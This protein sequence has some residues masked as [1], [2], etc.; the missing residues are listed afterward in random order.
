MPNRFLGICFD[1]TIF[2][3]LLNRF[4]KL[5]SSLCFQQ[6]YFNRFANRLFSKQWLRFLMSIDLPIDLIACSWKVFTW[7]LVQSISQSI[8]TKLYQNWKISTIDCP[9]DCICHRWGHFSNDTLSIDLPI[10]SL[11]TGVPLWLIQSI[12]QS[13]CYHQVWFL[14]C[15]IDLPIDFLQ[16]RG[17]WLVHFSFL[18]NLIDCLIDCTFTNT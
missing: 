1:K 15:S 2:N 16:I 10:D 4:A 13:I 17:Y 8:A 11:S 3:R 14:K 12:Y 9:I 5:L 6:V 18:I 7:C